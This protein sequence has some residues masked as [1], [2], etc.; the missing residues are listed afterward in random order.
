MN[1]KRSFWKSRANPESEIRL[2]PEQEFSFAFDHRQNEL[3]QNESTCQHVQ[4]QQI[5]PTLPNFRTLNNVAYE[6]HSPF[7]AI[8]Q[9]KPKEPST[10][11]GKMEEDVVSWLN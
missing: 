8:F 10:F 5:P 2:D 11:S 3:A 4:Y 7:S 1:T 6:E 9:I